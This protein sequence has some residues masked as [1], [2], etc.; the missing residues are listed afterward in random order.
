MIR[1]FANHP[2]AANLMMLL[3]IIAGVF[4]VPSLRRE[5]FPEFE[6][7]RVAVVV[8][9]AGASAEEME[10]AIGQPIEDALSSINYL[11]EIVAESKEGI[12]TVR[13]EMDGNGDIDEFYSDIKAAIDSINTLP[14]EANDPIVT[15][16][17]RSR[18]CGGRGSC[19]RGAGF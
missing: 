7:E 1:F 15:Q 19:A 6:S 5:T 9:Y 16:L 13:A 14:E 10:E 4:A 2:T 18:E 8:A 17:N 12:T 11:S 3:L